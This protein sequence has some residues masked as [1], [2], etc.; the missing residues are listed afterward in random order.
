[1]EETKKIDPY[2]LELLNFEGFLKVFYR[3]CAHY[4]TQELAYDA[5]E[6]LYEANFGKRKYANFE[7]F[8]QIRNRFLKKR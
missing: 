2:I 6:R 4:S 8:R 7:S 3:Y 1:M 5:V